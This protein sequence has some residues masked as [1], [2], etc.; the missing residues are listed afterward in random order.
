MEILYPGEAAP[1]SKF[2]GRLALQQRVLPAYRAPFFD[3]LA[4]ACPGGLSVFAGE[5]RPA[6][7]IQ[8]TTKLNTA[9]FTQAKN[10]H[11][12]SGAL[13]LCKQTGLLEWLEQEDPDALIVEANPRYLSTPKAVEWMHARGR[14]VLGWGLGAPPL[15]G[16]LAG[17]RGRAR[18]SRAACRGQSALGGS[19]EKKIAPR[20]FRSTAGKREGTSPR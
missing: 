19:G 1:M 20:S 9:T 15:S 7:S 11:I 12:F 5:P 3:T 14:L 6:E 4:Q 13:Y 16:I 18:R 10:D 8:T 17:V 2:S